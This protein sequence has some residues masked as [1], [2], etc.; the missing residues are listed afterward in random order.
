MPKRILLL[1]GINVGGHGRLLMKDVRTLLEDRGAT[2]VQTYM[3]SGN[4][5]MNW[6][7]TAE[8]IADEIERHHGF[9]RAAWLLSRD[10]LARRLCHPFI[11]ATD[12]TLH[13]WVH[14]Q[15]RVDLAP[16][17]AKAT[18]EVMA[19][20]SGQL[21]GAQQPRRAA[22]PVVALDLVS[23]LFCRAV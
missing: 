9:R 16:L 23:D 6:D 19:E 17:R 10:E 11:E 8:K 1:A 12:K 5:V 7:G 20:P 22:K 15:D 3:Q 13:I 2:D 4:A 18:T 14:D 21:I